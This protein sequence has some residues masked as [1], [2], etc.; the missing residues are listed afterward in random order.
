MM[1][2]PRRGTV[3]CGGQ[4]LAPGECGYAATNAELDFDPDGQSL[5]ARAPA[6][7]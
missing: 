2:I 1:V 6:V 4:T 5:I 7:T 3:V